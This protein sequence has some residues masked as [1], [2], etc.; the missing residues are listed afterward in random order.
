MK[1]IHSRKLFLY[2]FSITIV[3]KIS[4]ILPNTSSEA[5]DNGITALEGKVIADETA[6]GWNQDAVLVYVIKSSPIEDNGR[7]SQW[8]FK[9]WDGKT[10]NE[11]SCIKIEVSSTGSII[12]RTTELYEENESPILNWSI[13]SD[14]AYELATTNSKIKRYLSNYLDEKIDGFILFGSNNNQNPRW[15]IEWV[16]WGNDDPHWAHIYIDAHTGEILEVEADVEDGGAQTP[17]LGAGIIIIAVL[18]V[19]IFIYIKKRRRFHE[20]K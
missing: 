11:T 20:K 18:M 12:T 14:R 8:R 2:V 7:C 17:Y 15:K 5:T 9:Y 3:L 13:D 10:K 1:I 6:R 19:I 4:M 16:S